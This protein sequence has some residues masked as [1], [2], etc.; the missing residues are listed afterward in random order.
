[1]PD[2]TLRAIVIVILLA[3]GIGHM[4]GVIPALRP[5]NIGSGWMKN[6][7]SKSWLWE[8]TSVSRVICAVLFLA[9]TIIFLGSGLSL[10]GVLGSQQLWLPLAIAA[11]AISL[12]AVIIYWNALILLF[13]HKIGALAV[14]IALLAGLLIWDWPQF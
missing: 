2:A 5:L 1:M 9:A 10:A 8:D 7:S 6:W 14:D 4:M 13:P 12:L 3:H 11:S